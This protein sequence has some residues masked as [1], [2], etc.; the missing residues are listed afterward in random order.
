MNIDKEVNM[1]LFQQQQEKVLFG[2]RLAQYTYADMDDTV[3]A[4]L[5]L[6]K[7]LQ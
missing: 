1:K 4:A 6:W 2:G 3:A 7:S 5:K